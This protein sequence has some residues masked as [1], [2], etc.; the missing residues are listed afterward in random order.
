MS[1]CAKPAQARQH[2]N[3]GTHIAYHVQRPSVLL[4]IHG[5]ADV[6]PGGKGGDHAVR[7]LR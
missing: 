7:S 2:A 5:N 4:D 3:D 1:G 6:P